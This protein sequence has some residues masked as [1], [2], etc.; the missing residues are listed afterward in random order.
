[1]Y[2]SSF[3]PVSSRDIAKMLNLVI[4]VVRFEA[5]TELTFDYLNVIAPTKEDSRFLRIM[6]EDE[7]EHFD[8]LKKVYFTLTGQHPGGDP[9]TFEVPESFLKGIHDL[10]FQK[11]DIIAI[12]KKIKKLSPYVELQNKADTFIHDELKHLSILNYILINQNRR[13]ETIY[14]YRELPFQYSSPYSQ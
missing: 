12:Y 8:E 11:L 2:Y 14:Q 3:Q 6:L 13:D 5:I 9:P 4:E 10:F 7:R 1:M